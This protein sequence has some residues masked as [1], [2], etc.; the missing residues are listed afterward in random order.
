MKSLQKESNCSK[1]PGKIV[2]FLNS[3]SYKSCKS[4]FN[5]L[6]DGTTRKSAAEFKAMFEKYA[7]AIERVT[8]CE[9]NK[10]QSRL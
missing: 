4:D 5:T 3:D 6:G 7:Q 2:D 1:S 10:K 8:N 9:K